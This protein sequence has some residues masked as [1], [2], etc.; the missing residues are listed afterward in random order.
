LANGFG[1]NF[2]VLGLAFA[3]WVAPASGGE[4]SGG[5]PEVRALIE[6][7]LD[8]FAR[9]DA[10]AAY[11]LAAP[12]LKTI[13]RDPDI[14]LAIVRGRYAPVYRHRSIDF[15]EMEVDGENVSQLLTIVDNHNVVWKALYKLARQAD[16]GWLINGCV[17][18]SSTD[19]ST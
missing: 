14:F 4:S 3:L 6:R 8:A 9:D 19:I 13:F 16:G 10:V 2:P 11:A 7:Q 12:A 18:V 5:A 15:G 17:L 1:R